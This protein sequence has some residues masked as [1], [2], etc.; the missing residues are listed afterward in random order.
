MSSG[1]AGD[2][3]GDRPSQDVVRLQNMA[4]ALGALNA[5]LS[6]AS[7]LRDET[8]TRL[9]GLQWPAGYMDAE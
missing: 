5:A 4:T 6:E 7:A 1:A 3:S 9:H 2:T 8:T